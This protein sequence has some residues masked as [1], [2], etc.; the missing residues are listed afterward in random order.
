[1]HVIRISLVS[2]FICSL[3]LRTFL[4]RSGLVICGWGCRKNG[5]FKNFGIFLS[6]TTSVTHCG[7]VSC[8]RVL[9][10]SPA[11][12]RTSNLHT[13]RPPTSLLQDHALSW[14]RKTLLESL[15]S[16]EY[17]WCMLRHLKITVSSNIWLQLIRW[18]TVWWSPIL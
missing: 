10:L 18:Y 6:I 14:P 8:N 3:N 9:S 5:I 12:S 1:M 15:H 4:V 16:P 2:Y 13:V 17:D 7:A 11:A